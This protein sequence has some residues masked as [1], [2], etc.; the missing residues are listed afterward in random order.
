M[1]GGTLKS[2]ATKGESS[3]RIDDLKGYG[4]TVDI[5][6]FGILLFELSVGDP[7]YGGQSA[8][9]V[10][11]SIRARQPPHIP[12]IVE[13]SDLRDLILKLIV[14]DPEQ[15]LG[16]AK[17]GLEAVEA[18]MRHAF[19]RGM[20]WDRVRRKQLSPPYQPNYAF[21]GD[22]SNFAKISGHPLIIPESGS[23]QGGSDSEMGHIHNSF[24]GF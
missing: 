4:P 8:S 19:F 20:D 7:P 21:E 9:A 2:G 15:R 17:D 23:S 1:H 22:T 14:H 3:D 12:P 13:D 10:Y 24:E 16:G 5:W 18:V 11:A 6:A